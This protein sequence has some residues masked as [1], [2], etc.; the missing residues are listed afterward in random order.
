[1]AALKAFA[2]L[3]RVN[4]LPASAAPFLLGASLAYRGGYPVTTAKFI[5][6][7]A[8]VVSA[9]LAGNAANNYYDYVSG[10]DG[11]GT[12]TT[13]FFGGT[14]VIV[15]GRASPAAALAA[16]GAFGLTA[17]L[18]GAAVFFMTKDPVFLIMAAAVIF[19]ALQYTAAPLKLSYR[20][21][22]EAVIFIL[23]GPGLVMGSYYLFA[24][25]FSLNSFLVS[26]V[27]GFLIF[28]VIVCNEIPDAATDVRAGKKNLVSMTGGSGGKFLYA[29][30]LVSSIFFLA[31]CILLGVLPYAAVFSLVFYAMAGRALSIIIDRRTG[32]A[33]M[34]TAG[35]L[36]VTTHVLVTL[37]TAGILICGR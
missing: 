19:L 17:V 36:T 25:A 11:P 4:F 20:G 3:V 10:A 15:D 29:S 26:L 23:F 18:S 35:R 9:H 14:K 27:P 1:M 33:D 31:V 32:T 12:L 13:P 7:L 22:G 6:A 2:G 21:L 34:V 28:N 30:G 8:G 16:A 5:T 24:G 37:S